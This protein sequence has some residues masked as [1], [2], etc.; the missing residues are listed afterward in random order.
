MAEEKEEEY[1]EYE[2]EN[3]DDRSFEGSLN[4]IL[5][6]SKNS[7][8]VQYAAKIISLN[9][10]DSVNIEYYRNGVVDVLYNVPVRHN[11]TSSGFFIIKLKEGDKGVVRFFDDDI[12]HYRTTGIISASDEVRVHDLN[13]NIFENGFYPDPENYQ[14]PD[15]DLVI[16][17][18]A[19]AL[20]SLT[21]N[22]I[23]ISGGSI[24]ISGSSVNLGSDVTIDGKKFLEH[25]H[26]N[27]NEGANTGGVI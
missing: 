6:G 4:R 12:E 1:F 10:Q 5:H 15:G 9:S 7:I 3:F 25:Q 27:G 16:G 11:K 24:N 19:G 17:T 26:S 18:T 21:G 22:G 2:E 14:Y 8:N 20:I 23:N 13:D